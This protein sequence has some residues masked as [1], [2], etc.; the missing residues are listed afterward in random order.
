[1]KFLG[2]DIG[3]TTIS[4]VV[5]DPAVGVRAAM[6]VKNDTFLPG[7]Y[8]ERMQDPQKIW[9]SA[10]NCV[11]V[12]L[13]RFPDVQGIGVTGQMHGILY[14]N[15][16]GNAVSPLYTWQDGRG[17][18]PYDE[19]G[20]WA[21][22]LSSLTRYALST[23]YGMV[24]HY[25][26]LCRGL[27]PE[28]AVTLCTI[29]DY[30]AMRLAGLAAPVMDATDAASLGLYDACNGCF[31]TAAL[32]KAG[33]DAAMLPPLAVDPYLGTGTLG[34]PVYTAIGDNQASFLGAT[35]GNRDALL[36]NMGTGGQVSVFT[37][38][39]LQ[40]GALETRPFPGGGWLLVGASLCGGRSYAL[41]EAFL[42]Q[43]VKMVTGEEAPAYDAMARL[44]E[45][46]CPE[47]LPKTV[48]TF[49]GTRQ[50][51]SLRGSI[52]GLTPENFTPAHLIWSL[53][54][55]MAQELYG[56]YRSFLEQGGRRPAQMIGS[57]N[58]LRKNP[59]LCR[60]LEDVFGCPMRL[61]MH[62]EEAACGAAL[63]AAAQQETQRQ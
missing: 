32:E 17:D 21:H 30:V 39:Y 26:H 40:T 19:T 10:E 5:T 46:P 45:Q 27:V 15:N 24:T 8:W 63:Y 62:E 60:V 16:C 42:R 4:A 18:L 47:D 61:S 59:A 13:A 28:T 58:G 33:I 12:M 31:D 14:L 23:G 44:L 20:S 25:Y 51:P 49:Q 57:G 3:T 43:T 53:M 52:C 37:P 36:I 22:H 35:D 50:D 11:R 55:G 34:I 56:M 1:M 41:L 9:K 54:E 38:D 29:H 7:E 6:N 2:V 48:T